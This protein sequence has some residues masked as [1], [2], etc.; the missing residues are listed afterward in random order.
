MFL[1]HY[2]HNV[3]LEW[4]DENLRTTF[5]VDVFSEG[6][7]FE[8][9]WKIYRHKSARVLVYRSD[10]DR[11]KQLEVISAFI[12]RIIP[13]WVYSNVSSDKNYSELY[14]SFVESVKMPDVYI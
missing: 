11:S 5:G 4:F 14:K 7:P 12:G 6:F 9:K 8:R 2:P 3:C 13:Q 1:E 10:L